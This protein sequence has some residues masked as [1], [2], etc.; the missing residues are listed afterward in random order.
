MTSEAITRKRLPGGK[1]SQEVKDTFHG[2]SLLC[3]KLRQE[4]ESIFFKSNTFTMLAL[5]DALKLTDKY[6]RLMRRINIIK[7]SPSR[8]FTYQIVRVTNRGTNISCKID[9][10]TWKI[11]ADGKEEVVGPEEV[12]PCTKDV[13][14]LLDPGLDV[15]QKALRSGDSIGIEELRTAG[16]IMSRA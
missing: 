2:L 14:D 12:T 7:L 11:S 6:C 16:I 8:R 1:G 13:F 9:D 5:E 3:R 15:L 4:A 10:T